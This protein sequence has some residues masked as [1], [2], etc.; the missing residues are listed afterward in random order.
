MQPAGHTRRGCFSPATGLNR[1]F[2]M[3]L[4]P[5]V[6]FRAHAHHPL[7]A[8]ASWLECCRAREGPASGECIPLAAVRKVPLAIEEA[9]LRSENGLS[10]RGFRAPRCDSLWLKN[11][12][13]G[14]D[15]DGMFRRLSEPLPL[16]EASLLALRPALNTPVL[17]VGFLPV[18]PARAA[19]IAFGEEWGGIGLALGIRSLESR[20]VVVFRNQESIEPDVAIATALEPILS[21]AERMGFLFDED[22]FAS[23]GD[24]TGRVQA[25]ALW[26]RLMGELE[27]PPAPRAV[28]AEPAAR[29]SIRQVEESPAANALPPVRATAPTTEPP[30]AS[31]SFMAPAAPLAVCEELTLDDRV[32]ELDLGVEAVVISSPEPT[33]SVAPG[34]GVSREIQPPTAAAPEGT[35]EKSAALPPQTPPQQKLSKFRH[36]DAAV[37]EENERTGGGSPLG[38]IPLVRVRRGREHAKKPSTLARLLGS[39]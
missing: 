31:S 11:P 35:A 39:F 15:G 7:G 26:G 38:R 22:M 18:G 24:V 25:M 9:L 12:G 19:I 17:N 30:C 3:R 37:A 21:E 1:G 2:G 32:P 13:P 33:R 28:A 16:S 29:E 20:Q 10:D 5:D 27:L 8:V 4:V 6:E 36:V 34:P 14:A 23:T